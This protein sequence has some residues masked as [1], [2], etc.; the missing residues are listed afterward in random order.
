M[1]C[2]KTASDIVHELIKQYHVASKTLAARCEEFA[3]VYGM[4]KQGLAQVYAAVEDYDV[5]SL[6]DCTAGG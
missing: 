4:C 5:C 3:E 2:L 1:R 6:V